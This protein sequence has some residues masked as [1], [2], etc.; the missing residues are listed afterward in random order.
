MESQNTTTTQGA[1][2]TNGADDAERCAYDIGRIVFASQTDLQ[3]H[4]FARL[5]PKENGRHQERHLELC[6]GEFQLS[7][8]PE[9]F[10]Q[11]IYKFVCVD[12]DSIHL[13]SFPE[14][15]NV[16]ADEESGSETHR[17]QSLR[18]FKRSGT[19]KET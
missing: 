2:H 7:T 1:R 6:C 15:R 3:H 9:Y 14:A 4:R 13:H 17:L 10:S 8:C 16:G 12:K 19:L 11:H 18:Q 5:A